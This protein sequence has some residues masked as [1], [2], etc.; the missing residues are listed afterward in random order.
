MWRRLATELSIQL[1]KELQLWGLLQ[2]FTRILLQGSGHLKE[3]LLFL[4]TKEY[5]LLM[6]LI[7]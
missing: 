5:V 4:L 7:R 2:Q 3:E 6:N 1:E